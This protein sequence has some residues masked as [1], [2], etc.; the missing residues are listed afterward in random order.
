MGWACLPELF[1]ALAGSAEV[2]LDR[3]GPGVRISH[4]QGPSC[5]GCGSLLFGRPTTQEVSKGYF[6][7]FCLASFQPLW[8][9]TCDLKS[10]F[11]HAAS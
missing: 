4:S 11:R 3:A 1:V 2:V 7:P 6:Q 8:L 5:L 10:S 9:M